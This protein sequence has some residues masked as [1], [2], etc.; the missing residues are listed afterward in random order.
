MATDML[1]ERSLAAAVSLLFYCDRL[2]SYDRWMAFAGYFTLRGYACYA[3]STVEAIEL[4]PFEPQQVIENH[5]GRPRQIDYMGERFQSFS[6]ASAY[7]R[8]P[9]VLITTGT[10]S[11]MLND[12]AT[13]A[14][15]ALL[16]PSPR[17]LRQLKRHAVGL[18]L[19]IGIP[20][21]RIDRIARR[22]W[23]NSDMKCHLFQGLTRALPFENGWERVAFGLRRWLE[24]TFVA[25]SYN[26][27]R[28]VM[29]T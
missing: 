21:G 19:W 27:S 11:N 23:C 24:G 9:L 26:T 5:P 28:A 16:S 20:D 1:S 12:V 18:P 22:L 7:V 10:S 15:A 17:D 4:V 13:L 3:L 8:Q 14:G 6:Q 2:A 25:E 29:E